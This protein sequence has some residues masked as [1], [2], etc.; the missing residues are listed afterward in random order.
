ML[1]KNNILYP[2][3]SYK[4]IGCAF[5]VFNSLGGGHK[6]SVYQK[7][8]AIALKEKDLGFTREQYYPVKY[9]NIVVGKNFFDFYVEEKIVVELKSARGFTKEHYDQVANYLNVS[10]VKLAL[11]ITFG[12]T[13]VRC[14]RVVNFQE[15]NKNLT[16]S[17]S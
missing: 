10:Q 11:L 8:L 2:E 3:L 15:L 5:D 16:N 6:E 4:I 14:K 9:N 1:N 13:E 17:D 12:Q 7:A